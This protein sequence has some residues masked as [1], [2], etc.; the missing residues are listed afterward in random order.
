MKGR[1][2][3]ASGDHSPRWSSACA[4][5]AHRS[6]V[7]RGTKGGLARLDLA[8][9]REEAEAELT[10]GPARSGNGQ[11]GLAMVTGG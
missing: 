10:E 3:G 11:R 6:K 2:G 1:K 9:E 7:H 5:A 4:A 8:R